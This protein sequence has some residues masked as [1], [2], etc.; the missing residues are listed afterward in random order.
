ME[1]LRELYRIGVGPSSSHTMGPRLAAVIFL[2]RQPLAASFHVTLYESLAATGRGHLTDAAIT[3]VFQNRKL[4]LSW[5]PNEKLPLHPN[6]MHFEAF[7]ADGV[8]LESWQVYSV[9]G[10]ALRDQG[11]LPVPQEI[12]EHNSMREIL[13]HCNE[14]NLS[15]WQ[16][17]EN[18]E[19]PGIWEHLQDVWQV[20]KAAIERG[21]QAKGI[22]PGSLKLER[23]A[24]IFY[25][26]AILTKGGLKRAGLIS[27]YALAVSEEN[28]SAGVIVTALTC[29]S[30]GILPAVLYYL[31]GNLTCSDEVILHALAAAGLIGSLAKKNASISGAEVGCQGEVG[32]AC[33]MAA[34]AATQILGGSNQHI[35]YAA[36]IGRAHV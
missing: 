9:G 29:G 11:N 13:A 7:S 19:G 35:E 21:L 3:S 12:Y 15:L 16:Y 36:E 31:Q 20:M 32:V 1:S 27:A 10:G 14:N 6:G 5:K 30:C 34:G 25:Q 26:K 4:E 23:K 17:V 28:A 18:C 33:A 2:Q 8:S 22:L 24:E